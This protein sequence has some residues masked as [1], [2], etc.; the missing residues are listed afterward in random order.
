[1]ARK[2][3]SDELEQYEGMLRKLVSML[4]G[5][6]ENLEHEALGEST[7]D[8]KSRSDDGGDAYMQ[9]LSLNLLQRDEHTVSEVIDALDRT[10]AGSFGKCE[11]CQKWIRRTRLLAMP[12]ARNCIDCQ[13]TEEDSP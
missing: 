9:E 2:P 10:Q 11:A 8:V 7:V 1:M 4:T 5:D 13:R 6:I 12:H 3:T